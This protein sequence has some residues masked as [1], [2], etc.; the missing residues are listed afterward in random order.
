MGDVAGHG[1]TA[2]ARMTEAKATIR[3]LVL[4]VAHADVVPAANRSL[5]HFDSGYIATAAIAWV[6][7]AAGTLEWR[8]AGHVPPVLRT[9][10]GTCLLSGAHHPPI[11]TDT[12]PRE[13]QSISFPTG[14]LLVLY[15][16]GLV[17]RRDEDIDVGFERLR[18]LVEQLPPECTAAEALAAIMRGLRMAE[19]EDDV[20]IVVV[21]NR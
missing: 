21:R 5:A 1:I 19:A 2:A 8:L 4:N 9:D 12:E 11:G 7:T 6:D 20:A 13:Q 10:D 3:T 15:T 14:S 16:D 17:E 18:S